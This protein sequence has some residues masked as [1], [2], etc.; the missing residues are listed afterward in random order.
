MDTLRT[1][2]REGRQVLVCGNGG[3][4]ANASHFV[5]DLGKSASDKLGKRFRVLSLNDA[6]SW[7]TAIGN[8]Y[9]YEDVFLRRIGRAHRDGADEWTVSY[10]NQ[11]GVARRP[12]V[13]RDDRQVA[14]KRSHFERRNSSIVIDR[15]RARGPGLAGDALSKGHRSALSGGDPQTQCLAAKHRRR[16]VLEREPRQERSLPWLKGL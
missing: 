8:D 16:K 3:S 14:A 15:H 5:T 9:S 13:G 12:S 4:A 2:H 7:M 1:A 10:T 11:R 6:V